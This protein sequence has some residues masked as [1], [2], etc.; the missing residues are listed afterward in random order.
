MSTSPGEVSCSPV[1]NIP[2]TELYCIFVEGLSEDT[3][4]VFFDGVV[5]EVPANTLISFLVEGVRSPPSLTPISGFNI[6]TMSQSQ[7]ID[8]SIAPESIE[9]VASITETSSPAGVEVTATVTSIN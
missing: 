2:S 4:D 6:K 3:L 1:L 5:A 7:V 8:E 9:L